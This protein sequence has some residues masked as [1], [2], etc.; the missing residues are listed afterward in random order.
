L[1][2]SLT[3]IQGY[4]INS[5]GIISINFQNSDRMFGVSIRSSNL[6]TATGTSAAIGW[7]DDHGNKVSS[8]FAY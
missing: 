4:N 7:G 1:S 8:P 3:T 6:M 2:Q 5:F